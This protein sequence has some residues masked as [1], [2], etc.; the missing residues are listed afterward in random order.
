MAIRG[1]MLAMNVELKKELPHD[2]QKLS[3]IFQVQCFTP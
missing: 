3:N 1:R 2:Q